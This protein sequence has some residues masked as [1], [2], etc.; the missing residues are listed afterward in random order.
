MNSDFKKN[1]I[2]RLS[3]IIEQQSI[4][5]SNA[6]EE[7]YALKPAPNKWSR[8]ETLGHLIDS[9]QNNIQR[10][11]R[12]Q[13]EKDSS[14]IY[15]QDRWVELNRYQDATLAE[16]VNLWKLLNERI[17]HIIDAIS[18]GDLKNT[19]LIKGERF[20]LEW[21]IEDYIRHLEHHL[22]QINTRI[23]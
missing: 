10:F 9:A 12:G 3:T 18:E 21:L 17:I 19:S 1:N 16:L 2:D 7:D 20:T 5:L 13:Y 8:K 11:I 23:E 14:I 6:S 4:L 22:N 15:N